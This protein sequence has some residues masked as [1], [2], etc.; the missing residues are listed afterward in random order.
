[1]LKDPDQRFCAVDKDK[2]SFSQ[3]VFV[4]LL[5]ARTL[6]TGREDSSHLDKVSSL[7][8]FQELGLSPLSGIE[9]FPSRLVHPSV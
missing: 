3:D 8:C 6:T 4:L 7:D 5:R 1:V 9:D 2:S